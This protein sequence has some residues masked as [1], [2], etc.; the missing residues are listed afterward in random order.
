[1]S[2]PE[3]SETS[4]VAEPAPVK[5][6]RTLVLFLFGALILS[7]DLVGTDSPPPMRTYALTAGEGGAGWQLVREAPGLPNGN[8]SGGQ[9]I[10]A[11]EKENKQFVKNMNGSVDLPPELFLF[12]AQPLPIN[13]ADDRALQLLPGVGPHLA[14]EIIATRQRNGCFVGPED[15]AR[16]KGIGPTRLRQLQPLLN[17]Q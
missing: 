13:R 2:A 10:R 1:M 4:L 14:Q 11:Q 16:V 17:F 8:A 5:D 12:A 7:L 6:K 9:E 15:L 3:N